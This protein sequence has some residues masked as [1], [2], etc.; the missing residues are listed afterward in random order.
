MKSK[1]PHNFFFL[2]QPFYGLLTVAMAFTGGSIFYAH[3]V[4]GSVL[5][6]M[7]LWG[8]W[9][10]RHPPTYTHESIPPGVY[11]VHMLRPHWDRIIVV[12][13]DGDPDDPQ[14]Q[15]LDLY[16]LPSSY[17]IQAN[18]RD[19]MGGRGGVE[20]HVEMKSSDTGEGRIYIQLKRALAGVVIHRAGDPTFP[21]A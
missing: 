1:S 8:L 20:M 14:S 5:V 12:T 6:V 11:A 13:I 4:L 16:A 17:F 15:R 19:F 3:P 2:A 10:L 21:P 18:L 7:G 9:Q